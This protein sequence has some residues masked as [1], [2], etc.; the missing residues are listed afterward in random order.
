[1]IIV[2]DRHGY[3]LKGLTESEFTQIQ[4]A[5]TWQQNSD[6]LL[7]DIHAEYVEGILTA[8]KNFKGT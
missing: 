1:M 8:M 2:K 5:L 4:D 3:T 7:D 6:D